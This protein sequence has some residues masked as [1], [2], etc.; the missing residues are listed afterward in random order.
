M[1]ERAEQPPPGNG[2]AWNC[3][4]VTAGF[5][6][7]GSLLFLGVC[8]VLGR[9]GGGAVSYALCVPCAGSG[10]LTASAGTRGRCSGW[11]SDLSTPASSRGSSCP[12]LEAAGLV[13]EGSGPWGLCG[14]VLGS[15]LGF[16]A[17]VGIRGP[18]AAP[19]RQSRSRGAAAGTDIPSP[20]DFPLLCSSQGSRPQLDVT[21]AHSSPLPG[22][23]LRKKV[24]S[25]AGSQL[26]G[27]GP[28]R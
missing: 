10:A 2:T 17:W 7:S 11:C 8:L 24:G 21:L 23:F 1:R 3:C 9:R 22:D 26:G 12:G 6:L 19:P 25:G 18:G 27:S 4:G 28:V 14:A 20:L 16:G 5:F 13:W 15:V